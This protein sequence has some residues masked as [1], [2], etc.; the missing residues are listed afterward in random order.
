[1]RSVVALVLFGFAAAGCLAIDS[2]DG[3]LHCSD[4]PKRAC[5]AGFY[6]LA[7]DNTCWRDG[8]YP[9]FGVVIPPQGGG[10]ELDFSF[11]VED[12]LSIIDAGVTDGQT[13]PD[14]LS[15]TD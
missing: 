5:P 15:Q 4:V 3:A 14:D 12:D 1:M 2:P 13:P 9:D 7:S 11:A 8:H 6:C 10:P